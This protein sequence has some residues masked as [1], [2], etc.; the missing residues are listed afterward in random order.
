MK[1]I[2]T[3]ILIYIVYKLV[4]S[5]FRASVNARVKKEEPEI[6]FKQKNSVKQKYENIEE[7][8]FYEIKPDK[9]E[10]KR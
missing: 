6:T 10:D 4:V 3:V 8:K 1:F 9:E 5:F 2:L 7:A